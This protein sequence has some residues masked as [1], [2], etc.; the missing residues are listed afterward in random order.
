MNFTNDD[1]KEIHGVLSVNE[2]LSKKQVSIART[3][4]FIAKVAAEKMKLTWS[5]GTWE[6][7]NLSE[8]QM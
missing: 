6:N 2:A 5:W 8:H 1:E 4:A 7:Q 3:V